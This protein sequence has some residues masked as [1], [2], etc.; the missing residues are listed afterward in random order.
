MDSNED[1]RFLDDH[2]F[3]LLVS[4]FGMQRQQDANLW[5]LTGMFAATNGVLIVALF[6]VMGGTA[7][8]YWLQM[9]LGVIGL[10]LCLCWFVSAIRATTRAWDYKRKA[11]MLQKRLLIPEKY[12]VWEGELEKE[13]ELAALLRLKLRKLKKYGIWKAGPEGKPEHRPLPG[14]KSVNAYW[15]LVSMFSVVWACSAL[16]GSSHIEKSEPWPA[17]FAFALVWIAWA[18]MGLTY[19]AWRRE[20]RKGRLPSRDAIKRA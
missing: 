2:G 20:G 1:S 10:V 5:T 14:I 9:S 3:E 7:G 19:L 16:Y 15:P 6:Q 18:T 11:V 12:Q 4:I 17:V 8:E 13:S